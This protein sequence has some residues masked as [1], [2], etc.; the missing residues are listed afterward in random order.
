MRFTLCTVQQANIYAH[1]N[2]PGTH[3]D[4]TRAADISKINDTMFTLKCL[5]LLPMCVDVYISTC[6]HI[7][8]HMCTWR[9]YKYVHAVHLYC[10]AR[11]APCMA[12]ATGKRTCMLTADVLSLAIRRTPA[13]SR[14]CMHCRQTP[15]AMAV[16]LVA[17]CSYKRRPV[18]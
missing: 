10:C 14:P 12:A 4:V 2:R 17:A 5:L 15:A 8:L 9:M 18:T 6:A 3:A 16:L 7:P 13:L 1:A 11:R